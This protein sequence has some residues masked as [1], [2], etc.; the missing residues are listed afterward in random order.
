MPTSYTS[1]DMTVPLISFMSSRLTFPNI[2]ASFNENTT[3]G[4]MLMPEPNSTMTCTRVNALA[5]TPFL[6]I[7]QLLP[8]IDN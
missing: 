4:A 5:I 7:R 1:V 8:E 2:D 3:C 6:P